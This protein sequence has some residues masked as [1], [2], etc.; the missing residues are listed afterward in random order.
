MDQGRLPGEVESSVI[1]RGGIGM[2]SGEGAVQSV[3]IHQTPQV[4]GSVL[5]FVQGFGKIGIS[6]ISA[7]PQDLTVLCQQPNL[8]RTPP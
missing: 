7:C 1:L 2:S 4:L 8:V 3:G 6:P 5:W